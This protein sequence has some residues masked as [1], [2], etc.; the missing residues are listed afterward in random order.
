[1]KKIMLIIFS[2]VML[3][4]ACKEPSIEQNVYEENFNGI[5]FGMTKDEIIT[6]LGREPDSVH[7]SKIESKN[8]MFFD[9]TADHVDY[10]FDENGNLYLIWSFYTHYNESEKEQ[11]SIDLEHV[12]EVLSKYYPEN[13]LT[14]IDELDNQLFLFTESRAI[15]LR[16]HDNSFDVVI[17][18]S[19]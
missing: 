5:T 14:R 11:M 18:V 7:E 15:W 19:D 6:V 4:T 10:K 16:I 13:T 8:Q 2:V 9:V 1:M 12:K 17:R 3:F